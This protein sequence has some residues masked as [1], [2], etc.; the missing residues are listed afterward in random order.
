M[1]SGPVTRISS[2]SFLKIWRR[3]ERGADGVK[4]AVSQRIQA[5]DLP[6]GDAQRWREKLYQTISHGAREH[7]EG[8]A[9]LPRKDEQENKADDDPG[10]APLHMRC[11]ADSIR[12][13]IRAGNPQTSPL[14]LA[15][16]AAQTGMIS[17]APV[18]CGQ[19]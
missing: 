12:P 7:D 8:E 9:Y 2:S 11:H 6:T 18:R 5:L 3:R 15:Y 14:A 16:S 1:L 17:P 10:D 4:V 19:M 13:I